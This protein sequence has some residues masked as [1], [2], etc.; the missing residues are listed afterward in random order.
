MT[1]EK[2]AS[3]ASGLMARATTPTMVT[4]HSAPPSVV[5]AIDFERAAPR[6][7]AVWS[8]EADERRMGL[9]LDR[10]PRTWRAHRSRSRTRRERRR[11]I[12]GDPKQ[13]ANE[14][15]V[16]A[17]GVEEGGFPEYARR[18]RATACDTLE[19]VEQLA[20]ARSM[21]LNIA[22]TSE[23]DRLRGLLMLRGEVDIDATTQ[24]AALLRSVAKYRQRSRSAQRSLLSE[25]SS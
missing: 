14:L 6:V 16:F 22:L 9:W 2:C 1:P 21:N 19:L 12:V 3:P 4:L 5:I 11:A 17:D 7:R 13:R 18:A 23:R 20:A 10:R 15:I 8:N 24:S 25:T